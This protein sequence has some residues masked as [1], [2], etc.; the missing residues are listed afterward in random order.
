MVRFIPRQKYYVNQIKEDNMS[1]ACG[2]RG[3]E[4]NCIQ[5]SCWKNLKKSNRLDDLD[6]DGDTNEIYFE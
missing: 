5:G 6:V 1:D 2:T 4:E 3:T